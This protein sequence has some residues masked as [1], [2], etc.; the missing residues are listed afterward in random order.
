MGEFTRRYSDIT[1][2]FFQEILFE[3]DPRVHLKAVQ[4][5]KHKFNVT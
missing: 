4:V 2:S 1:L 5:R 3:E